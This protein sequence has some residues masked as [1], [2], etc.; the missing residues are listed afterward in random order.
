MRILRVI[1]VAWLITACGTVM[2][3][4]IGRPF[5]RQQLF[6]GAVALGTLAILVAVR[7]L[8]TMGWLNVD[9]RRGASICAL[10]A[11]ALAAP[12]AAMNLDQALVPLL[13]LSFVGVGMILGA[14][15]SAAQ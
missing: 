11:F 1:V 5:G 12:L 8:A 3:W 2:G 15:P 10:C 9:R 6:L 13:L 14:G 4:A 7:V